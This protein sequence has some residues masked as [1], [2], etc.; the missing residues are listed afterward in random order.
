MRKAEEVLFASVV[1]DYISL[2]NKFK[3]CVCDETLFKPLELDSLG[4]GGV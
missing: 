3:L 4:V 1:L 2:C